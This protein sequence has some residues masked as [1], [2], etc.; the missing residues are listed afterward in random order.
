MNPPVR[1]SVCP[2][3]PVAGDR[4]LYCY[5]RSWHCKI[6]T[7]DLAYIRLGHAPRFT[8]AAAAHV[9]STLSL[10]APRPCP[11]WVN[12]AKKPI[13]PACLHK[14]QAL[15]LPCPLPAR[16]VQR[17]F[18]SQCQDKGIIYKSLF[19]RVQITSKFQI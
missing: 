3:G 5:E 8:A 7:H 9:S 14:G 16:R 1:L 4:A 15:T 11:A 6:A 19:Q 17:N 12:Y 13:K 2:V 10:L 18:Y